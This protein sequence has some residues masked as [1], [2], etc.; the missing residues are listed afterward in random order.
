MY[1]SAREPFPE[2]PQNN[3][4]DSLFSLRA[5]PATQST[6]R[7]F[8]YLTQSGQVVRAL[9]VRH[10]PQDLKPPSKSFLSISLQKNHANFDSYKFKKISKSFHFQ[11]QLHAFIAFF[12]HICFKTVFNDI[13]CILRLIGLNCF[14]LDVEKADLSG[15]LEVSDLANHKL[16]YIP[17]PG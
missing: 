16:R 17:V 3:A 12:M 13:F 7:F 5:K 8:A 2:P 1:T 14:Y 6:E 4:N 10:V 15:F 11:S 9:P